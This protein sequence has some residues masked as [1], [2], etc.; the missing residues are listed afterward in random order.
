[1]RGLALKRFSTTLEEEEAI[2]GYRTDIYL[3]EE[4]V[5]CALFL[6]IILPLAKLTLNDEGYHN[7][8]CAFMLMNLCGH[9]YTNNFSQA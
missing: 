4:K 6:S 9:M 7:Y 5:V 8:F 2:E 1:L 3:R